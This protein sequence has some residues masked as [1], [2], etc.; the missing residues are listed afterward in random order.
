MIGAAARHKC[1]MITIVAELVTFGKLRCGYI[2]IYFVDE[3]IFP[4]IGY[5]INGN[6]VQLQAAAHISLNHVL[7]TRHVTWTRR[8]GIS[9]APE[10]AII[11]LTTIYVLRSTYSIYSD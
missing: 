7:C 4:A 5:I 10:F 11:T 8:G 9:S 3:L 6:T 2:I 1:C